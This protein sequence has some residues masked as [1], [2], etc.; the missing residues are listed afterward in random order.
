MS[1]GPLRMPEGGQKLP[2]VNVGFGWL[3]CCR[4]LMKVVAEEPWNWF[5]FEED[6]KLYLDVLVEHGAVSFSVTAELSPEQSRAFRRDGAVALSGV[7]G[8][9]R[10]QGS[11]REWQAPPLPPGWS[12]RSVAA[13]HEWRKRRGI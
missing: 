8:E 5:L 4:V 1:F 2:L 6:G 13:V 3:N 10:H 7:A 9:M 12:A 11:M